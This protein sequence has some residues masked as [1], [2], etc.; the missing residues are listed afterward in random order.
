MHGQNHIKLGAKHFFF[1][2]CPRLWNLFDVFTNG[3]L[4]SQVTKTVLS[5]N[6]IRSLLFNSQFTCTNAVELLHFKPYDAFESNKP[7][8]NNA[9]DK[10]EITLL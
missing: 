6:S 8:G 9:F 2:W 3:I 5:R 4:T 7:A 1:S 10:Q